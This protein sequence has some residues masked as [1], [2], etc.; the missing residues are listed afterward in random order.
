MNRE[1]NATISIVAA[2]Y[3]RKKAINFTCNNGEICWIEAIE[4][5]S[6]CED[7]SLTNHRPSTQVRL[8]SMF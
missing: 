1:H 8:V 7:P 6:S 2:L 4:T 3:E 5:V